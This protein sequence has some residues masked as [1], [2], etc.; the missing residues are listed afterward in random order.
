[1]ILQQTTV[2]YFKYNEY[3][4]SSGGLPRVGGGLLFYSEGYY[5]HQ[6]QIVVTY[7]HS[8]IWS[9]PVPA[10]QAS[11][12]P[13]TMDSLLN[14]RHLSVLFYGDS[15]TVGANASSFTQIAPFMPTWSNLTV[16]GLKAR[17]GYNDISY[18]N[19]AKGGTTSE[20]GLQ[21]VDVNVISEGPDLVFLGFGTN[22]GPSGITAEAYDHNIR[23]IIDSVREIFP[24]CEF[25]LISAILPNSE[26]VPSIEFQKEYTKKLNAIASEYNG[27]AVADMTS[28]HETLLQTKSYRDM[29]GNNVNHINDFLTRVYAQIMLKTLSYSEILGDVDLDGVVTTADARLTMIT[30]L[31]NTELSPIAF[32]NGD[33]NGNGKITTTDTRMIL[34]MLVENEG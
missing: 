20:W 7:T 1:M 3:Y 14:K 16:Y 4:P 17:F 8:D 29:T 34:R 13:L 19:T 22:D 27:I 32:K 18:T 21:N 33:I 31:K 23:G 6:K 28:I 9:G 30:A 2:P 12:L 26:A 5:F 15:L 10:A 11:R 25:V 24:D